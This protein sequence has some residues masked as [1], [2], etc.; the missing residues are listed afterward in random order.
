MPGTAGQDTPPVASP[1]S[2][3]IWD[4]RG[5]QL[6]S[7]SIELSEFGTFE[8]SSSCP[9]TPPVGEYR[10]QQHHIRAAQRYTSFASN[11]VRVAAF[12]K[13]KFEVEVTA[14]R[15][16]YVHG[17]RELLLRRNAGGRVRR[18]GGAHAADSV[19]RRGV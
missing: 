8:V 16:D 6:L 7:T 5:N 11:S 15:S 19:P 17:D 3:R 13:P 4:A 2:V 1:Q 9:R 12:R 18:V 14:E 10:F